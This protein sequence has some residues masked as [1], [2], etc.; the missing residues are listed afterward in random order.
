MK[1]GSGLV[2]WVC[3]FVCVWIFPRHLQNANFHAFALLW[4][5]FVVFVFVFRDRVSLW[6]PGWPRTPR[7]HSISACQML[8]F[9]A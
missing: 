3:L 2:F 8:G 1:L 4:F 7:R 6:N 9:Q 5:S